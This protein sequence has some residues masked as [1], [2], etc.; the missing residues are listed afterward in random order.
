MTTMHD[1]LKLMGTLTEARDP[2]LVY[3]EEKDKVIVYLFSHKSASYTKLGRKLQRIDELK[4]ELAELS[5][6][7]KAETKEDIADLFDATDAACTRVVDTVSFIF[8]L[9]KDP[10][11][12]ETY[13]YKKILDELSNHLTPEL[14]LVLS[15]IKEAYRSESQRAPS[16]SKK[17]KISESH[18]DV[19]PKL[20]DLVQRWAKRYDKQLDELEA[21]I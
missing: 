3:E 4:K 20:N 13:E 16:L 19:I 9:S 2:N 10:K 6:Q 21:L 1:L 8:T 14:L 18:E 11:A 7:V 15:T 17:E 5:D 12:T